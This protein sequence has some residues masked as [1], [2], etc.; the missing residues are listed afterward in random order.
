M[1]ENTSQLIISVLMSKTYKLTYP[2]TSE[3]RYSVFLEVRRTAQNVFP[4]FWAVCPI[5]VCLFDFLT[6][7]STTRLY[8]GRAG[9]L[10]D[11]RLTI[12]SAVTHKTE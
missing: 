2:G 11:R 10:Q 6:S 9:G 5:T 12:I 3:I 1:I 4:A 8:R 7:S